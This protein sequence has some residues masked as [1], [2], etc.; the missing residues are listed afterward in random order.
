MRPVVKWAWRAVVGLAALIA[1]VAAMGWMLPVQHVVARTVEVA[2]SA[3]AVYATISRVAD[4]PDWWPDM[5]RV[6][7]LD[8]RA[9]RPTFRQHMSTGPVVISVV[10]AVPDERWV[11]RIDD[12]DQPFGGTWTFD[13]QA[14]DAGR[15]RVTLTE[16][17]EVYN[18]IFRF[19]SRYVFGYTATI[20]SC[21]AALRARHS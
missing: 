19:L 10:D 4:Y 12:P 16:R 5:T 8:A 1:A 14:I 18:P 21:L 9:G 3:P 2:A 13:L 15:T 11:T 17:G 20:E 6:D 7:M